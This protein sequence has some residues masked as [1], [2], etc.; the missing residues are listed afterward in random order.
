MLRECFGSKEGKDSFT[1]F[2]FCFFYLLLRLYDSLFK[3]IVVVFCPLI[4]PLPL[5]PFVIHRLSD[6]L[7]FSLNRRWFN[8]KLFCKQF[9]V[10]A[11]DHLKRNECANL[12]NC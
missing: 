6:Q 1:L 8:G 9:C 10:C 7:Q 11:A 2:L 3:P 5:I 12:K 4:I